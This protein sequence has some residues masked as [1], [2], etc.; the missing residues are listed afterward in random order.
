MRRDKIF[1]YLYSR[2]KVVNLTNNSMKKI[3]FFAAASMM[4]FAS[5]RKTRVCVCTYPDGTSYTETYV[6]STKSNAEAYCA[7]EESFGG[8]VCA[9]N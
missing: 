4:L 8:V 9:L 1:F 2:C 5:C 6:L 3:L 7:A